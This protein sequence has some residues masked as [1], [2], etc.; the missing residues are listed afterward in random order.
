MTTHSQLSL[1]FEPGLTAKYKR[2]EDVLLAVVLDYG[3]EK[4]AGALDMSPSELTRRLN[5]HAAVKEGDPNNRPIRVCD[6]YAIVEESRDFRPVFWQIE[7]WL[8]DPESQRTQ[9]INQLAG[10]L[11]ALQSLLEQAGVKPP[12]A[13]RTVR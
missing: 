4:M 12:A 5:A 9:A 11:P 1:N 13:L 7:K 3:L 2:L 10:L 6:M 8:R